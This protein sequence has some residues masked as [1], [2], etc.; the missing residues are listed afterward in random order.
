MAKNFAHGDNFER[1]LLDAIDESLNALG[2][3]VKATVFFLLRK[4]FNLQ[5]REIPHNPKRFEI[6]FRKMLGE[7]GSEVVEDLILKNLYTKLGFKHNGFN[8]EGFC[9]QLE[10]VRRIIKNKNNLSNLEF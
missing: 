1:L 2:E 8:G 3:T 9:E 7:K 6:A 5:K 4:N 10:K